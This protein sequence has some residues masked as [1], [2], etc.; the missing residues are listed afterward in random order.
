M[1]ILLKKITGE[2]LSESELQN[3]NS[4]KKI[5][6]SD[7]K[8]KKIEQYEDGKLT[9]VSVYVDNETIEDLLSEISFEKI[10]VYKEEF[11][12]NYTLQN[13]SQYER[14]IL[15]DKVEVVLNKDQKSI[16]FRRIDLNTGKP[17][18]QS[19]EKKYYLRGKVKYLFDYDE[20]G[21]AYVINDIQDPQGDILVSSIGIENVKFEW[22]DLEYY[23]KALPVIPES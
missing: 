17:L 1:E 18:I 11:F 23:R 15:K 14:K 2:P 22:K 5:F 4:Y 8:K 9:H 16:L 3:I 10:S 7:G 6:L 20:D 19:T 12:L 21:N 13:I